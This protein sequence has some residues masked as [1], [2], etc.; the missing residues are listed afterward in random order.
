MTVVDGPTRHYGGF[1]AVA[2]AH[3]DRLLVLVARPGLDAD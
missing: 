3:G 2:Q 1:Y